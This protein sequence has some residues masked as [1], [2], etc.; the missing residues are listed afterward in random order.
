M[1]AALRYCRPLL[2]LWLVWSLIYLLM[3]FNPLAAIEQG[4]LPAMASQWQ[5]QL[6]N[7][8]MPGGWVA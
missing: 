8:S 2:G 5:M 3:P 4:Y 6:G 1:T 7:P